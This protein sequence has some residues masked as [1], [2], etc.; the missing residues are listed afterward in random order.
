[1][2]SPVDT[3]VKWARSTMPGAPVLTRAAGSLIGLL[4]ALLVNGWGQQTATSVVVAGGVAT[5]TGS[6]RCTVVMST[7][8][9][10]TMASSRC[11]IVYAP[12][13]EVP[14]QW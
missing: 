7:S 8:G 9:R 11:M 1:M 5:A 3:S 12:R 10:C 6:G 14:G 13:L 4:D 2:V